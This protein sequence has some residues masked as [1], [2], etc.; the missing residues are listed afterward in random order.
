[1]DAEQIKFHLKELKDAIQ[2]N[3]MGNPGLVPTLNGLVDKVNDTL[4]DQEKRIAKLEWRQKLM[5]SAF[6]GALT[7]GA[8]GVG[9]W[10]AI[11]NMPT[12]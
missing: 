9:I 11:V 8:T 12:P 2:G 3:D 1:M 10:Q 6:T 4:D 7:A 5:W